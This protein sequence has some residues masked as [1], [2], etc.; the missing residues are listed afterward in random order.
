MSWKRD[1]ARLEVLLR[2]VSVRFVS[3]GDI[4]KRGPPKNE[5]S[6]PMLIRAQRYQHARAI[7]RFLEDPTKAIAVRPV[8]LGARDG[9]TYPYPERMRTKAKARRPI[10]C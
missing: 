1:A 5:S 2:R 8:F 7:L 6:Y 3:A 9:G 10:E 4:V